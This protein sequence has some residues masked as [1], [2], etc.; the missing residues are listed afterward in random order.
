MKIVLLMCIVVASGM[1][2]V[3]GQDDGGGTICDYQMQSFVMARSFFEAPQMG[4]RF[5]LKTTE[6]FVPTWLQDSAVAF[7]PRWIA[8]AERLSLKIAPSDFEFQPQRSFLFRHFSFDSLQESAIL[9]LRF[10][11]G[12]KINAAHA[13][14]VNVQSPLFVAVRA[15]SQEFF[16]LVHGTD[17]GFV[18]LFNNAARGCPN[19]FPRNPLCRALMVLALE[20]EEQYLA[21]IESAEDIAKVALLCAEGRKNGFITGEELFL[22]WSLSN[23]NPAAF[24]VKSRE[25]VAKEVREIPA[26]Y[27]T[28]IKAPQVSS[29]ETGSELRLWVYAFNSGEVAE[30]KVKFDQDG[31]LKELDYAQEPIRTL[32]GGLTTES[33]ITRMMEEQ[34]KQH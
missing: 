15:G 31:L 13:P 1:S 9:D 33:P 24:T 34:Q 19:A 26:W 22:G 17:E 16:P 6:C 8:S 12:F 32:S 18:H 11:G 2:P 25:Q 10:R 20:Y 3:D 14:T 21:V 29:S 27:R 28:A 23:V 30:W 5:G 4:M 7:V